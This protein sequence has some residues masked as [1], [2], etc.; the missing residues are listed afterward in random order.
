MSLPPRTAEDCLQVNLSSK[1]APSHW[2]PEQCRIQNILLLAGCNLA[3]RLEILLTL[4]GAEL[5]L[6]INNHSVERLV[7][8]I[9]SWWGAG[10]RWMKV[11][12][13]AEN[14]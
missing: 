14:E 2:T 8:A 3:E 5:W 10:N 13:K 9:D 12:E 11:C 4:P 1:K 6:N 7:A